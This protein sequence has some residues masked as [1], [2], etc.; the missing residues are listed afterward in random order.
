LDIKAPNMNLQTKAADFRM[1]KRD[2]KLEITT[3]DAKVEIN[4]RRARAALNHKF[5]KIY[6]K[7]LARKGYQGVMQGIA[8]Y[9]QQGDQLARIEN[10]S[11]PLVSQAKF[12]S[13]DRQR[14]VGLKHKPGAEINIRRG[15]FKSSYTA[16]G[17]QIKSNSSW[18]EVELDWGRIES[19]LDPKPQFEVNAVDV[20]A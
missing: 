19:Y 12:N 14:Q 8:K 10:K 13:E 17:W 7:E 20:K 11:K 4:T 16:G 3:R 18:P 5:Y 2:G 15:G 6:S 9:A 1:S